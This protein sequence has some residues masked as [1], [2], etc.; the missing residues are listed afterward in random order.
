M[1]YSMLTSSHSYA[2]SD[3][4]QDYFGGVATKY[5][6][7]RFIAF[8]HKVVAAR[9]DAEKSLYALEVEKPDGSIINDTCHIL[10]NACGLL[11]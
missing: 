2:G 6:L 3:K 4:I 9:W 7:S 8:E 10:V 5:R 11:K 1:K